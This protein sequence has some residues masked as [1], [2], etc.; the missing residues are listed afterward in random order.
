MGFKAWKPPS[1]A[2]LQIKAPS[3]SRSHYVTQVSKC[4]TWID[5]PAMAATVIHLSSLWSSIIKVYTIASISVNVE[6]QRNCSGPHERELQGGEGSQYWS[7]HC[8]L[9]LCSQCR[10]FFPTRADLV[11]PL[12][13]C[14]PWHLDLSWQPAGSSIQLQQKGKDKYENQKKSLYSSGS[15]QSA[16][17]SYQLRECMYWPITS[18]K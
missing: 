5:P 2:P 4:W 6:E 12:I 8:S 9:Q 16:T 3:P 11:K 15:P 18:P 13:N 1:H 7:L 10:M 14:H 17:G